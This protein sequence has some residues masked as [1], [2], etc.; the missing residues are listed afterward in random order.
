MIILIVSPFFMS[1]EEGKLSAS[2]LS[3]LILTSSPFL[4]S[5]VA[6]PLA[7]PTLTFLDSSRL[8]QSACL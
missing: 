2:T 1:A 6:L 4:I 8:A 5:P 7:S 3:I